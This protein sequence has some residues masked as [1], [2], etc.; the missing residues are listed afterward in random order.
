[1]NL[2]NKRILI[3]GTGKSGVAAAELLNKQ[4]IGA[5]LYDGNA[6]LDKEAFYRNHP[7]LAD[8]PLYCGEL[9]DKEADGVDILVLSPGVPSDLK[10][11]QEIGRAHV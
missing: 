8:L 3:M 9:P 7:K 4:Q 5:V 1:M 6:G 2:K 11:V 10:F